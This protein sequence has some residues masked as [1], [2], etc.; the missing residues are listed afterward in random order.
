MMKSRAIANLSG[1][2]N[3]EMVSDGSPNHHTNDS[4]PV[5]KGYPR[6]RPEVTFLIWATTSLYVYRANCLSLISPYKSCL[7]IKSHSDGLK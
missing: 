3:F 2:F 7:V 6:Y 1:K 5:F 4:L